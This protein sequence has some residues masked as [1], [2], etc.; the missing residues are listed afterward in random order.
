MTIQDLKDQNLIIFECL[1]GSHAYGLQTEHSDIDIKGVFILPEKQFL[2]L[3]YVEQVN[4]ETNDT[5]YYELKR[6]MELLARNNPNILELLYS[7]DDCIRLIHPIFEQIRT[8]NF[9][10]RLC[11]HTFGGYAMTQVKKAK[12]LNKKIL[13]PIEKERKGVLDFCYVSEGQGS[14]AV[15]HFLK[16]KG[17]NQSECG[18]SRIAH[19]P[20]TYGV[21]HGEKA[22]KGIINKEEANDIALSSVP[23]EVKPIGV[24]CFNKSAYSIYCKDYKEYWEWV[25]KR[26]DHRY[27]NTLDHG[28]NY[29]A[30]N[31]MHTI[32]LLSIAEEI[33]ESGKLNVRR[34]D[35]DYLLSVKRG[36]F[37]YDEL[38]A[39]AEQKI[40]RIKQV[41][42]VS[43]LP[44]TPDVDKING[45][46]VS[47]RKAFYELNP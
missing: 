21:Y 22:Y 37:Q 11:E 8:Q 31:M 18:L 33:G 12:G 36:E 42:P 13:N 47:V 30:K 16:G 44:A 7:P 1:S 40:E 35:R 19:M 45:L 4:D 2:G 15:T 3:N 25:G 26:N 32:R 10:T 5:V 6:F 39:V 43:D 38:L 34:S 23:K 41:Y 20:D 14:I 27:Q 24:M 9:I 29:D 46:L 17:L 28:K